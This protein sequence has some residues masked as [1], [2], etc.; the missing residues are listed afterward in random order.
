MSVEL[1]LYHGNS[2]HNAETLNELMLKTNKTTNKLKE[3][4]AAAQVSTNILA[5]LNKERKLPVC[6][7]S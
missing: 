6:Y 5:K 1:E 3:P 2:V 4:K 7:P